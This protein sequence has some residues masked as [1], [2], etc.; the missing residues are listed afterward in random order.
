MNACWTS[1]IWTARVVLATAVG[2]MTVGPVGAAQG[3]E[4]GGSPEVPVG[5]LE[6]G[7]TIS[8]P[9]DPVGGSAKTT[10]SAQAT[11][12][13]F[14]TRF[15]ESKDPKP[16][17]T[18]SLKSVSKPVDP[19]A[20]NPGRKLVANTYC[21]L[22]HESNGQ[23]ALPSGITIPL[24]FTGFLANLYVYSTY[25]GVLPAEMTQT[26]NGVWTA[27]YSVPIPNE[28]KVL[29]G[30]EAAG[31]LACASVVY[32]ITNYPT[33]KALGVTE[34]LIIPASKLSFG[35]KRSKEHRR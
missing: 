27:T 21:D 12:I 28:G 26:A 25:V 31:G 9:I 17:G 30:I 34:K 15:N 32:D 11:S 4:F 18:Q 1:R 19:P 13:M 22:L 8:G 35:S 16:V 10:L 3:G 23:I 6:P 5:S 20:P 14:T 2:L 33:I 24:A 7:G 29:H